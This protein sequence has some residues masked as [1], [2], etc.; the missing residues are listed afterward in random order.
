MS[1]VASPEALGRDVHVW[2]FDLELDAARRRQLYGYLDAAERE[3]AD[4]FKFDLHRNRFIVSRGT[5]RMILSHYVETDPGVI[6]FGA[7]PHGKPYL[8]GKN[9]LDIRFNAT[10]SGDHGALAVG[11][12]NELGLDLEMHRDNPDRDQIVELYFTRQEREWYASLD[13][14]RKNAAFYRMWTCKEA[15]LKGLGTGL[16]TDLDSFA[17]YYGEEPPRLAWSE[18]GRQGLAVEWR[19]H[20][21]ELVA[22]SSACLA[23]NGPFEQVKAASWPT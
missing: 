13:E 7:G 12:E 1:Q 5:Q 21:L 11:R 10:D 19:L 16:T 4:R 22:G 23:V 8:R 6:E 9:P 14:D 15:Y 20:S 2:I 3:R 18:P 17:I